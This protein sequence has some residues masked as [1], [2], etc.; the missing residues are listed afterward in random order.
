MKKKL[1]DKI[2]CFFGLHKWKYAN[3]EGT[4]RCCDNCNRWQ[5]ASYDMLYGET[6]WR[7]T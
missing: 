1:I 5:E 6:I 7:F 2:K 3:K 4:L